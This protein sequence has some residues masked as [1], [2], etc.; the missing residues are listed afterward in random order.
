M[1]GYVNKKSCCYHTAVPDEMMGYVNGKSRC[2]HIAVFGGMMGY[3]NR[4]SHYC[5]TAVSDGA[6]ES[7]KRAQLTEY[8]M[9]KG[10][11]VGW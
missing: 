1:M 4:R 7:G 3:V 11:L 8:R 10:S 9:R 5:H 6:L 2:C